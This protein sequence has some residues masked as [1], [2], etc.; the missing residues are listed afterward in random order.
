MHTE[1]QWNRNH[2]TGDQITQ[3][4]NAASYLPIRN[5]RRK[6]MQHMLGEMLPLTQIASEEIIMASNVL[7][8]DRWGQLEPA[9]II[10]R[11]LV[12]KATYGNIHSHRN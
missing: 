9:S 6:R 8:H 3:T 11:L 4:C 1:Q 12:S 2:D 5:F 7:E 10:N